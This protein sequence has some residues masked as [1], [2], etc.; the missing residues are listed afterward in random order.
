M[1]QKVYGFS[2]QDPAIS[3]NETNDYPP[4]TTGLQEDVFIKWP[5]GSGIVWGKVICHIL[6]YYYS[7][8]LIQKCLKLLTLPFNIANLKIPWD[9]A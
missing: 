5:N 7:H 1:H 8:C 4:F 9:G 6:C 3:G 2:F